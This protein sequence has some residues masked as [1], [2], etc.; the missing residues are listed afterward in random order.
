MKR[1]YAAKIGERFTRLR[2]A[3]IPIIIKIVHD[4]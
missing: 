4:D 1:G 3:K 2:R